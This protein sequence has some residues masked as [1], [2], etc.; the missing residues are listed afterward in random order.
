MG[1]GK[2]QMKIAAGKQFGLAVINPLF[3]NHRLAF[4]AMSIP[5]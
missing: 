4:G 5:A 2:D 1:Q 3:F